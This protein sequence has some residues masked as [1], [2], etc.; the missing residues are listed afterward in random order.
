ME[1]VYSERPER[2]EVGGAP[3]SGPRHPGAGRRHA[4]LRDA[5]HPQDA[6]RR[7]A[8][9]AHRRQRRGRPGRRPDGLPA[10]L[11]ARS[12]ATTSSYSLNTWL[13]RIATNLSI[14]F[15]RS[16]RSRER[17]HGA[18]LH[19]VRERE[20][21]T[22]ADAT[23]TAEDREL[24]AALRDRLGQALGEAEGGF[25]LREMEDCDT[26][27]HRRDPGL[28]RVHGAQPPLQRPPDP[29]QGD[30]AALSRVPPREAAER[31]SARSARS[32]ARASTTTWRDALP[33]PQRQ[34]LREHLAA[35][36]ECR[37]AAAVAGRVASLRA[38]ARP[39]RSPAEE[40]AAILAAVRT[41]VAL[42]RDRAAHRIGARRAAP[43]R[44]RR[45]RPP[46]PSL[47]LVADSRRDAPARDAGRGASRRVRRR[48]PRRR[49]DRPPGSQPP[50]CRTRPPR[51]SNATV[52]DW[53]PGA[54]REEPRVVWI[55]D[56]GL[57]I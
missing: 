14:D 23:R 11:G 21:S 7:L 12:T 22:A 43:R 25:V 20:E 6:G 39:R 44:R 34:I 36:E 56:R 9:P 26:K 31:V 18:T 38:P 29:P 35:C 54:G 28:R 3:R 32:C 16:S 37:A 51:R 40:T 27:R 53:N 10:G 17:A 48:R 24:V 50:R 30:R 2:Q 1:L 19:L 4:L 8:R 13:Y 33:A 42:H 52:Y 15:L 57:D 55:V 5:R 41:G 46:R 47:L 49:R 45:R